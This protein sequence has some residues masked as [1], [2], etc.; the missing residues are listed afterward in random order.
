ML[1][2]GESCPGLPELFRRRKDKLFKRHAARIRRPSAGF[3]GV[4][5]RHIMHYVDSG[6]ELP[7][8]AAAFPEAEILQDKAPESWQHDITAWGNGC[9]PE[10]PV[11]PRTLRKDGKEFLAVVVPLSEARPHFARPAFKRQGAKTI[12]ALQQEIDEWI[13]HRNSKVR[14]ILERKGEI[15]LVQQRRSAN[16]LPA[17]S[18]NGEHTV[19]DCNSHF[20]T[21]QKTGTGGVFTHPLSTIELKMNDRK[22]GQLMLLMEPY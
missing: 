22:P 12:P 15:V 19:L 21:L 1:T 9:Y 5:R 16:I 18:L 13:A 4:W 6:R 14:F 3:C 11:I 17:G 8:S 10:L 20:V 7:R 2:R